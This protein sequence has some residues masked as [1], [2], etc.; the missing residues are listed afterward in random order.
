MKLDLYPTPY[1]KTNL[2]LVS[3]LIVRHEI[4]KLLEENIREKLPDI[5]LSNNF[6]DMTLKAQATKTKIDK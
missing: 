4:V 2:K 6:L 5:G 3:D 1:I